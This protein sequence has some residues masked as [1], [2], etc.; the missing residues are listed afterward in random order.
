LKILDDG[1]KFYEPLEALDGG[2]DG[3]KFYRKI[4]DTAVLHSKNKKSIIL[5][6]DYRK[7]SA[8]Y[9]LFEKKFTNYGGIKFKSLVFAND[10]NNKERVTKITY[11]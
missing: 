1:I 7:K 3:L 9:S 11:G 4:F 6:I 10:L 5:E 8:M 2:D